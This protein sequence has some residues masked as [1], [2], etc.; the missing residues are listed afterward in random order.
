[1]VENGKLTTL[2]HNLKTAA[3]AGI[4][5]TG[6]A[7]KASY[8][9]VVG[10]SPFTF[11]IQPK[12]GEKESLFEAGANAIS[13]ELSLAATG[14]M[15]ENGKKAAPVKNFTVSGNFFDLL[16]SVEMLGGDLE[17]MNGKFGSPSAL[18][19]NIAVAGK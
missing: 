16:K 15:L 11:Y 6:N 9:S 17:F 4:K 18:V 10:I 7:S 2:L 12:E 19:R 3:K 8:A 14:F 1:M 5:S 13:G